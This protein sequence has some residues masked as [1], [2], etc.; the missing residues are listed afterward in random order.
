MTASAASVASRGVIVGIVVALNLWFLNLVD[1]YT[2]LLLL[3]GLAVVG[4]VL[5]WVPALILRRKIAAAKVRAHP[6]P[7]PYAPVPPSG[8]P[9]APPPVPAAQSVSPVPSWPFS[10]PMCVVETPV[11]RGL[12]EFAGRAGQPPERVLVFLTQTAPSALPGLGLLGVETVKLSRVE[13]EDVVA[14]GNLDILGDLIERHLSKGQGY[15]VV[16]PAVEVL[17][18]ASGV[19]N[20][21]RLLDVAREI[22]QGSSGSVLYSVDPRALSPEQVAILERG[23]LKIPVTRVG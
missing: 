15:G 5:A 12:L 20:V 18:E 9:L 3:V 8:S 7:S 14:P 17:V 4:G 10:E 21:R 13:G 11:E 2:M 1:Q 6:P 22:A 23:A 16:L 19:K